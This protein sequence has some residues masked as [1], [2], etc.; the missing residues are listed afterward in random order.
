MCSIDLLHIDGLHTYASVKHD[1][2][3]WLPKLSTAR[4]FRDATTTAST[5]GTPKRDHAKPDQSIDSAP[6][7]ALGVPTAR[8][9][10]SYPHDLYNTTICF[11]SE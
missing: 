4:V 11:A 1:F 3:T 8:R 9:N 5:I 10:S 7:L 2:E 6:D